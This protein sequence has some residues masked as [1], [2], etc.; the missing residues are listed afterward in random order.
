MTFL[1][2]LPV[3]LAALLLAA[4]FFRAGQGGLAL[5]SAGAPMIL[6]TGRLWA[7]RIIQILL[8]AAS[9]VWFQAT[10]EFVGIRQA[11]GLPWTRL[12]AK[13][14]CG[15][16]LYRRFGY[17]SGKRKDQKSSGRRYHDPDP[18][19]G[20]LYPDYDIAGNYSGESFFPHSSS[21]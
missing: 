7:V 18:P 3:I 1:R 9:L 13:L 20:G 5:V 16:A 17:S 21:G 15:S 19:R 14:G 4:H 8:L 12:A 11:L 2:I 6:L 10:F